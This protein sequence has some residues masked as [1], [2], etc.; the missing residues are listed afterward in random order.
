MP[1][2]AMI[3]A[4]IGAKEGKVLKAYRD[5]VHIVTIGYGATWLSASFRRWYAA[6]RGP[7]KL[8]M[9]DTLSEAEA[10]TVLRLMLTEEYCP[11]VD[12]AFPRQSQHVRDGAY[13]FIINAG[14]GALK[15][16]WAKLIAAGD[17]AGGAARWRTT[18]TT[19]KGKR[20][21]G[22]AIRRQ[23]EA[24]L[25]E[26][27]RW[28]AWLRAS[29]DAP[30]TNT[31]QADIR[32]AQTWL[33]TLGYNPGPSDGVPGSRTVAA[34][35][36]FQRD[37]GQLTVDG[38]I[39]PAT[40]SALQRAIDLRTKAGGTVAAGGGAVAAGGAEVT[41]GAG[42]AVPSPI[43]DGGTMGWLGD[44]LLWGGILATSAVL[45]Y[46]AYR[47]RDELVAALKRL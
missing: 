23:E 37:H 40:L 43:P 45:C 44:V 15:W 16:S 34:T 29:T 41:T 9:G 13:S 36:R 47:Y 33:E 2:G 30:E 7:G 22:L 26:T 28:P 31:A 3:T 38:K 14:A 42:D 19:A 39:G 20:L 27:G 25:A 4:Y 21:P 17:I 32:Q 18:A 6:N 46:F 11:P 1:A 24:T 10:L 12:A 5:P 35:A 8:K